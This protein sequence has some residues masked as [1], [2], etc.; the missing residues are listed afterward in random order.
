MAS[1]KTAAAVDA[2]V[3]EAPDILASIEIP[4]SGS[5][6][7]KKARMA[8]ALIAVAAMKPGNPWSQ[9]KSN[10]DAHCAGITDDGFPRGTR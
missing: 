6:H 5:T 8:K 1:K 9:V 2:P 4:L 3:K 7:R 10:A